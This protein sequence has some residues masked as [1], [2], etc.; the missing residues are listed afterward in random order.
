MPDTQTEEQQSNPTEGG[1]DSKPQSNAAPDDSTVNPPSSDPDKAGE[2]SGKSDREDGYWVWVPDQVQ[3]VDGDVDGDEG[4][5]DGDDDNEQGL[6]E[7]GNLENIENNTTASTNDVPQSSEQTPQQE[8]SKEHEQQSPQAQP[9][10]DQIQPVTAQDSNA[11][12]LPESESGAADQNNGE[13]GREGGHWVFVPNRP[14][15]EGGNDAGVGGGMYSDGYA[16]DLGGQEE[17]RPATS[18]HAE[19]ETG[20]GRNVERSSE[21]T[22]SQEASKDHEQPQPQQAPATQE[23]APEHYQPFQQ[24][25]QQPQQSSS[26]QSSQGQEQQNEQSDPVT[27]DRWAS[28]LARDRSPAAKSQADDDNSGEEGEGGEEGEQ[29]AQQSKK[30]PTS[31][32]VYFVLL[33]I[34]VFIDV[35][36]PLIG[37][38]IFTVVISFAFALIFKILCYF[39]LPKA[40]DPKKMILDFWLPAGL[41]TV[42]DILPGNIA[43][44]VF[45]FVREYKEK[46]LKYAQPALKV[47]EKSAA[48]V[49]RKDIATAAEALN[50]EVGQLRGGQEGVEGAQGGSERWRPSQLTG[51]GFEKYKKLIARNRQS[52]DNGKMKKAA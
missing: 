21:Q 35:I 6:Q 5:I 37:F 51:S 47:V 45:A 24:P 18:E 43:I 50:K 30:P 11:E 23:Q 41:D 15:R 14:D 9:S 16:D 7:D 19:Q 42:I 8:A 10:Q 44:V 25:S 52:A 28:A 2:N 27:R 12:N 29:S 33:L 48:L 40:K 39:F 46:I 26:S 34:A 32:S 49:G 20:E 17:K 38:W 13:S 22:E 1:K 31:M 3:D 4:V 36:I